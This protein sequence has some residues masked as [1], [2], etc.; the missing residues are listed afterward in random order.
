MTIPVTGLA[1][2]ICALMLIYTAYAT[3]KIRFANKIG[4]GDG[5][6]P[7]LLTARRIHA[8]LAEHAP[9]FLIMLGVLELAGAWH[10]G[11]TA[12][13]AIFLIGRAA[14]IFG[15]NQHHK[16]GSPIFRQIGVIATWITTVILALWIIYL[17][18]TLHV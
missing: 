8:N 15:M 5:D 6:N 9:L 12:V 11:I 13:A 2:A 18:V 14:H 3:V 17:F 1:A 10:W 16:G 4:F 7:D